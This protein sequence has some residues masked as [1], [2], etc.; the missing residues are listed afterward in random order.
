MALFQNCVRLFVT[1]DDGGFGGSFEVAEELCLVLHA[2]CAFVAT[3]AVLALVENALGAFTYLMDP[4]PRRSQWHFR[5][6][7]CPLQSRA[8]AQALAS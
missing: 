6:L 5:V 3:E 8:P 4:R 2:S 7:R 1:N